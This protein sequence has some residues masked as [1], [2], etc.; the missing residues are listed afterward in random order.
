MLIHDSPDETR[1]IPD[2]YPVSN[3]NPLLKIMN[4]ALTVWGFSQIRSQVE[5]FS[6]I[7]SSWAQKNGCRRSQTDVSLMNISLGTV[8][9]GDG[10]EGR[11][12]LI[13]LW[14]GQPEE[15]CYTS[16]RILDGNEK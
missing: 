11:R 8:L 12:K 7:Y 9:S 15:E 4:S 14:A 5:E 10:R 3:P 13:E 6:R 2:K 16:V 1:L